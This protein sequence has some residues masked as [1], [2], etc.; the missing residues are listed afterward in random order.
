MNLSEKEIIEVIKSYYSDSNIQY[1]ILLNGEWGCGKTFFVKNKIVKEIKDSVYVS[2]YGVSN[3]NDVNKKIVYSFMSKKIKLNKTIEKGG[4]I[5]S[6]GYKSIS[7]AIS[8]I[9]K[10]PLPD[11]KNIDV[12]ELLSNF[13]D[14]SKKLII[15]D[16]LERV[17]IPINEVLGFIND[18][19]EHKGVKCIIVA[20]ESEIE[21]LNID[22]NY[23]LKIMSCLNNFVEYN[24]NN[25]NL[26]FKQANEKDQSSKIKMTDLKKR[27]KSFY[28]TENKYKLIKEKLIGKTIEYVP[29]MNLVIDDLFD[30]Y[31]SDKDYYTF[32]TNNKELLLELLKTDKCNNL[33]TVIFII[34]EYR[35]IYK[36]IKEQTYGDKEKRILELCYVN[37]IHMAILFKNGNDIN[38]K[39][40]NVIYSDAVSFRDDGL[41]KVSDY[42][43][44]FNFISKYLLTSILDVRYMEESIKKYISTEIENSLPD[45]DPYFVLKIYWELS[46]NEIDSNINKM[47]NNFKYSCSFYP[48][49]LRIISGLESMEIYPEK[50]K[51]LI[52]IMSKKLIDEKIDFI[53]FHTFFSDKQTA[54]I[55]N[56]YSEQ[57]ESILCENRKKN[58]QDELTNTLSSNNWGEA[59]YNLYKKSNVIH[60]DGFFK[61][62][63]IKLILKN[64]KNGTTRDIFYFKYTIDNVYHF[65][66]I[67]DFY[68]V[69]K[70]NIEVL[71]DGLNKINKEKLDKTK[72]YAIKV[73][74]NVLQEQL[75]L[76]KTG[77]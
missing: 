45:D 64:I 47:L 73:L 35:E 7:S 60:G 34:S 72:V 30:K 19:V 26:D 61:Q 12:T 65:N 62:L 27:V 68:S 44:A 55:Y 25:E 75:D 58:K 38:K 46:D 10:I 51:Q 9:F 28:D 56:K 13:I 11:A 63:D 31:K 23:E 36:K 76:L 48:N 22:N 8:N 33:R 4:K 41:Q 40:N 70:D 15:F 52:E 77:D 16:D 2:L 71:I 67:K 57:F 49:I 18:Y 24:V 5:V 54:D 50:V 3:I 59:L 14:V 66:N 53:D 69:D 17:N 32:L 37:I 1:A 21:K 29:N 42:F 6:S 43:T 39:L 20:N 74:T